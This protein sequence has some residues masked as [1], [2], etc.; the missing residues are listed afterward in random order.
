MATLNL[1]P[2]GA[3]NW[4]PVIREAFSVLNQTKP[5]TADLI[6]A[7]DTIGAALRE[8]LKD[9]FVTPDQV[10]EPTDGGGTVV[11]PDSLQRI[12]RWNAT[13]RQW[14]PRDPAWPW[15]VLCLS[16]NDPTATPPPANTLLVGD[17]WLDADPDAVPA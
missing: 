5:D 8:A 14:E 9:T 13:T 16:T 4:G 11:L 6:D 15:G 17:Y 10:P 7:Q 3:T 1:P 12:R 2:D